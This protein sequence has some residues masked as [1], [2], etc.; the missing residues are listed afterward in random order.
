M[1]H[2]TQFEEH[3]EFRCDRRTCQLADRRNMVKRPRRPSGTASVVIR[4]LAG[5]IVTAAGIVWISEPN[6]NSLFG[7]LQI[8]AGVALFA[9][10]A[11][12]NLITPRETDQTP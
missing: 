11:S 6:M 10:A 3:L 2:S 12:L 8:L 7:G 4:L 1:T 9:E 5:I